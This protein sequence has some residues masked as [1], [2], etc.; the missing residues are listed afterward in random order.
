M[1]DNTNTRKEFLINFAYIAVLCG[2]Y[3]VTFRFVVPAIWPFVIAIIITLLLKNP[4][5]KLAKKTKLSRK[6][7]AGIVLAI[8]YI[9]VAALLVLVVFYTIFALINWIGTLPEFYNKEIQPA[10]L[11]ASDTIDNLFTRLDPSYQDFLKNLGDSLIGKISELV[12]LIS[13]TLLSA[14]QKLVVGFPKAFIGIMFSIIATVFL[15]MDYQNIRDFLLGQLSIEKVEIIHDIKDSL[16]YSIVEVL[17]SYG[18]I[19]FITFIELS[20]A[21]S[22]IKIPHAILVSLLISI[23]DIVPVLGV[24]TILIPWS[25]IE[26][27]NGNFSMAIKVA[28]IYI[29]IT[30]IRNYIEPRIVGKGLGVSSILL[31]LCMYIG[32]KVL[33]AI[34]I[35]VLPFTLVVLK[36]LN[37][38][39][40]I[41]VFTRDYAVSS[42]ET[43]K[44]E[45]DGG[46]V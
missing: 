40:K 5:E 12:S 29:V 32:A 17:K 42:E 1:A 25:I 41:K 35:I 26:L 45:N 11:K 7:A 30:I 37:D 19:M 22:I 6:G 15:T 28:V 44:K 4:I 14:A 8:F 24:G 10:L 33:G 46:K 38:K 34:G 27:I 13:K 36:D 23:I 31:L 2:I 20:I 21:L 18:I 43:L 16:K 9:V 3:F 39:G